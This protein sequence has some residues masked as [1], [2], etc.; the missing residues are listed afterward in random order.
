MGTRSTLSVVVPAYNEAGRIAE[1][2]TRIEAALR[3]EGLAE[4][5]LEILVVDDGSSDGT[6]AV[7]RGLTALELPITLVPLGRNRGKG[8]AV[9]AGVAHA[10]GDLTCF[11][12][13]DASIDPRHLAD[14]VRAL[15]HAPVAIGDRSSGGR[16]IAYRSPLRSAMGRVFNALVRSLSGVSVVDT[17][18]G[19]KGFTT[20]AGRLLLG[21]GRIEGFAFDVELLRNAKLLGLEVATVPVEWS[22][23]E[24]SHVRRLLDPI[25]MATALLRARL[26][27]RR[28][29]VPAVATE[30]QPPRFPGTVQ[31]RSAGRWFATVPLGPSGLAAVAPL[32]QA[33]PLRLRWLARHGIEELVLIP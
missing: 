4:R 20:A 6:A 17:Q 16:A 19:C 33:Q 2:L 5:T 31:L 12:D 26:G 11:I 14:I 21:L 27:E 30:E 9:R 13:A 15:E 25:A 10:R 1:G 28:R 8:A 3:A 18:C 23:V 24:G 22:D 7:V 29:A 32:G